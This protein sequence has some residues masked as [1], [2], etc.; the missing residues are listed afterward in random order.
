MCNIDGLHQDKDER[1]PVHT[2]SN[3]PAYRGLTLDI[4]TFVLRKAY[5]TCRQ[6]NCS[7]VEKFDTAAPQPQ[8]RWVEP[9]VSYPDS[10]LVHGNEN[11]KSRDF[12]WSVCAPI[13]GSVVVHG[14]IIM[15]HELKQRQD[16]II[17]GSGEGA[18]IEGTGRH[19]T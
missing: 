11:R 10:K 1:F 3:V 2:T 19:N 7:Y 13:R 18:S 5:D 8:H 14:S 17:N 6:S 9:D 15:D 12:K 4:D 16:D